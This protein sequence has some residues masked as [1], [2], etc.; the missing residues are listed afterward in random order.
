MV[1]GFSALSRGLLGAGD[2]GFDIE[3]GVPLYLNA[4]FFYLSDGPTSN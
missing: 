3:F 4:E 2:C 1:E